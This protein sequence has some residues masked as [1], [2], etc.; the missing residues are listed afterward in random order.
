MAK[1]KR[2]AKAKAKQKAEEKAKREAK[3][4]RVADA[5]AAMG[6]RMGSK[7]C[8]ISSNDDITGGE[9]GTVVGILHGQGKVEVKFRK[10]TWPLTP[11]QLITP[12][13]WQK[14]EAVRF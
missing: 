13:A 6:R 3:E 4:K 1:A 7:W 14:R 10:V 5:C 9:V 2:E 8:L 11:D 12:G